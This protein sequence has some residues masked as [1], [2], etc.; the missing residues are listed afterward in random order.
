[1]TLEHLSRPARWP[2]AE[3]RRADLALAPHPWF[4]RAQAGQALVAAA[5]DV[6]GAPLLATPAPSPS[7][8]VKGWHA[9]TLFLLVAVVV[10]RVRRQRMAKYAK[11][12]AVGEEAG[13]AAE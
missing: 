1:M 3:W 6:E 5:A 9:M 4:W 7:T 2:P 11:Y 13:D 10:Y 12:R 8:N